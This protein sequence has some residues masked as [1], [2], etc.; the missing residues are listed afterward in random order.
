MMIDPQTAA[1]IRQILTPFK[2]E[3]IRTKQELEK[4]R[5]IAA[6]RPRT[7]TEEI[8]A[9]PGRR[10]FFSL[11][12][13]QNFTINNLGLAGDAMTF[14]V[15]QD[16]PFIQTHYPLAMW[17]PSL[18]SNATNLGRWRPV[19]TWPL[20]D[21]VVD[22]D[23]IDLSYQLS[24]GGSMRSFQNLPI[25][26]GL[27]SRPDNMMPL[28]VPTLFTPNTPIQVIPTYEDI[29]FDGTT[30]PTQGTLVI[31]LPGYRIVNL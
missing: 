4:V 12:Q 11:A 16:G 10:I 8:D 21:Q 15:S 13:V 1:L 9:I 3:L 28:P 18:P 7:V 23:T 24:D 27:L 31:V 22:T 5:A 25:P 30:P 2:N 14:L 29:N 20:P 17:K 19:A 26:A 6:S